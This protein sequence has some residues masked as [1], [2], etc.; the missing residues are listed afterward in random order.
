MRS[1]ANSKRVLVVACGALAHEIRAICEMSGLD[2]LDLHC[3]PAILHNRPDRIAPAVDD[4]LRERA[5]AYD[6]AFVAYADCGTGGALAEVCARHGVEMIR[7]PHC[8]AFFDGQERFAARDET[9]AF[10]VTDFLARQFDAF[11][12]RPLGLDRHPELR[13]M[14]FGNYETL[15][16]LAQTDDPDLTA[17]ARAA[18]ERLGLKF[19]RRWTGYGELTPIL[20]AL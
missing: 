13:D 10:Y 8:Y 2:H 17:R 12:T 11:V 16:L 7:G 20:S 4:C 9:T 19:E 3:L 5:G 14:Y 18:A 6:S 1:K 15:V